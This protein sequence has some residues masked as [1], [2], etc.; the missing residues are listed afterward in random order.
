MN[1]KLTLTIEQPVIERAKAY[2]KEKGRSLSDIIEN[3]LKAITLEHR[4]SDKEITPLV[5]SLMGSF[6]APADFDYKK[7]L[8]KGLTEKYK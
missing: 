5:R 3:Y 6:K 8:A 1:T 4:E 7:E 2:A